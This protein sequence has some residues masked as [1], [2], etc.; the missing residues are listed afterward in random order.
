MRVGKLNLVDLAGS[1]RVH[2]SG[3]TGAALL[4][5]GATLIAPQ[6]CFKSCRLS[7]LPYGSARR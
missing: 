2:I 4:P 3:A 5:S 7:T 6:A 1:E